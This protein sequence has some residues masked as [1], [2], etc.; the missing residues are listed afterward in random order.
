MKTTA[1]TITA[2]RAAARTLLGLHQH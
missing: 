2:L 1:K